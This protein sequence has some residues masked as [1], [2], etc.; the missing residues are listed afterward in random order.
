MKKACVWLLFLMT[1]LMPAS[2]MGE[3]A[4]QD[5]AMWINGEAVYQ[6]QINAVVA[7]VVQNVEQLGLD[8]SGEEMLSAITEVARQQVIEDRL[9]SQDMTAQGM[10]EFT[11]EDES[12]VASAVQETMDAMLADYTAYYASLDQETETTAEQQAQAAMEA[13]GY[14]EDFFDSYYRNVLTSERYEAWLVRD[15]DDISDEMVET[16]YQQRT[17]EGESL[18]A[19]DVAAFETALAAGQ[20]IWYRPSGY[21]AILQIMLPAEGETDEEK[22]ES[23]RETTQEIYARLEAGETF[24]SLLSEYGEDAAFDDPAFLETGYQV[25]PDSVLWEEAFVQ[26]AFSQELA[27]PGDV[28]QPCV[29]GDNVCILYYLKDVEG[30]AAKLTDDLREALRA[31]L[32]AQLIDD[33]LEERLNE[34]EAEAEIVYPQSE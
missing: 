11:Q 8:T 18:Y 21:R 24:E 5:V 9:L 1:L 2:G 15:D 27:E 19:Q 12:A 4:A 29:L 6:S 3:D 17:A 20:E 23:V 34:L 14:T 31:D 28:S 22:L 30:G 33:R 32:Y 10:Y 7:S 26:S 25:H 13:A 16:A